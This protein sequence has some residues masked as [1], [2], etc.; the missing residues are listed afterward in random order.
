MSGQYVTRRAIMA[1][2]YTI[3]HLKSGGYIEGIMIAP[4]AL[5][6]GTALRFHQVIRHKKD[7]LTGMSLKYGR[8]SAQVFK[9]TEGDGIE[10]VIVSPSIKEYSHLLD[11]VYR[12]LGV[13][14][15]EVALP[16]E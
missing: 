4:T 7:D 10:I 5:K 14:V 9:S 3:V 13:V 12:Q 15:Q 11:I 6:K 16:T 2:S 8:A 1:A